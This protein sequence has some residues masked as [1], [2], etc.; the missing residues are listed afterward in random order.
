MPATT[1]RS[2]WTR[3]PIEVPLTPRRLD[4]LKLLIH[5]AYLSTP[6]FPAL[7]GGNFDNWRGRLRA[8]FDGGYVDRPSQQR[9]HAKAP[10]R[11]H[12]YTITPQGLRALR[13][14]RQQEL[15]ASAHG[16][17]PHAPLRARGATG[18]RTLY[19]VGRHPLKQE[20]AG[21]VKKRAEP[22]GVPVTYRGE[23]Y[24]VEA[25]GEPFGIE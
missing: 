1:R 17:G 16:V 24:T 19:P 13:A 5:Y 21:G 8:L 25:D 7:L 18:G 20:H 6:W 11:S 9:Q 22:L 23:T 4:A 3:A 14:A 12:V 10:Y 2:S 15:P